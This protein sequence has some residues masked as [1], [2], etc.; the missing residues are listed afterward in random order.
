MKRL[1]VRIFFILLWTVM[2]LVLTVTA[3]MICSV[4]LLRPETLTPIVEKIA[5]DLLDAEVSVGRVKLAFDPSFP[6]LRLEVDSLTVVSDAL[7]ASDRSGLPAYAD[8]LL[9]LD[10]FSGDVDV[11]ALMTKGKIAVGDVEIVRPEVNIVFDREGRA[12]FDIYKAAEDTTSSEI[13][14]FS[15]RHF[16]F[17]DPKEIRYFNEADSAGATVLR[18]NEAIVEGNASDRYSITIEGDLY[19]PMAEMLSLDNVSL[20]VG[21]TVRW[22][23]EKKELIA[24]ED[25]TVHGAFL[26]AGFDTELVF[27]RTLTVR[28]AKMRVEPFAL[29]DALAIL[30]EDR[31]REYRLVD[32]FFTTDATVSLEA[33]LDRPFCVTTDFIPYATVNLLVPTCS[34]RYGKADIKALEFDGQMILRG[35][36]V[37][38]TVVDIRR[39]HISGPATTMNLT[40]EMSQ[41]LSD[42]R[43]SASLNGNMNLRRLPPVLTRFIPGFLS[44]RLRFNLEAKGNS[45]MFAMGQFHKLVVEGDID[46]N[47]IY[48]VSGDTAQMAEMDGLCMRF[49]S[50]V[51]AMS[52]SK[53]PTLGAKISVDTATVLLGG[54]NMT[55]SA[56]ELA[57]GVENKR[58]SAD[59]TLVV[60]LGGALKIGNLNII[61]VADSAGVRLRNLAGTASVQ[62]FEGEKR[63]P[64][65]SAD[66]ELGS[67][68]AGTRDTR[69]MM[70]DA[71]LHAKTYKD[72]VKARRRA[73]MK[74]TAD[75]IRKL[76]PDLTPDSVMRLAIE[77]HRGN[78]SGRRRIGTQ[79]TQN[80]NE[81]IDWAVSGGLRRYLLDWELEGELTTRRARLMTPFF[82]LRTR[83]SNLDI[84]FSTDTI[85]MRG[86]R[87]RVGRTDLSADGL[88]SNIKRALTS[89]RGNNTLKVDLVLESDTVDI[90]Q[91]ATAAFAG[92]AYAERVAA[93]DHTMNMTGSE[94]DMEA[95]IEKMSAENADSVGAILIPTNVEGNFELAAK[96]VLYD[97]FTFHNFKSDILVYDGAV[98][99]HDLTATSDAGN[100]AL[101]ALYSAPK[102]SEIQFGVGLQLE[103]FR[104]DRFLHLIPA[105]DSIMPIVRD[106]S[107][108]INADIAATMDVDS[109]MNMVLPT[110]DAAVRLSGDSLAFINPE[111]YATLG[112]WLRFRN[113]ADNKIKHAS[114]EMLV[115]D[116]MLQLFPFS[117]DIDRYRLGILGYN[118]LAMNFN[119]HI[120][121]LKSPLP[122][123][124]GV[125]IKGNPDKYKIRL[126]GA[127]YKENMALG[128]S[129]MV[130]TVR[131]NLVG[132][133]EN[134][135]RR[136]VRNSKFA[137][138]NATAPDSRQMLDDADKPF[139]AADS[140]ALIREGF[141]EAPA[142]P[143]TVPKEPEK[144][145]LKD[146]IKGVFKK[147]HD[148][149]SGVRR[150]ENE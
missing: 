124:F 7:K 89:R 119:Y 81:V 114:V 20:G 73:A 18:L 30:P 99:L 102:A 141:I 139:T 3:V 52:G 4:R 63:L 118:D 41:M 64:V 36:Q 46:G 120:S 143:V 71:A 69:F 25:F 128:N 108:I 146:K 33:V 15:I 13:P 130:D 121:V 85:V 107:G 147:N 137:T 144:K 65:I 24:L 57:A 133:I 34:M 148:N 115:R 82:P 50:R 16:T 23:Q 17:T 105:V 84:N 47:D 12:N 29:T 51:N 54:I 112:K 150:K 14:Q 79:L 96:N 60:P 61:S 138:I 39:F 5:N 21:G 116:N 43:F 111:T 97:N 2:A 37:D 94:D 122:F 67:V 92:S 59:T 123:K 98:N 131:V 49:N 145:S 76:H 149:D 32:P 70:R 91:L 88:V 136:G 28:S 104:I 27:G 87:C 35:L 127:K 42:P 40:A 72:P 90:N 77:K 56:L 113:R 68:F 1:I 48:Y 125:N 62:R 134:V 31:L 58:R 6:T 45:S 129:D 53:S 26:S 22:N 109:A 38:S 8:T 55:G 9:T 106:F 132:Q 117:F 10:A 135:F 66:L 93:G 11:L 101:S 74:H 75:S 100:V 126:G 80:D 19:G 110:L 78:R 86:V 142:E 83:L 140:A 44:G 103:G 95:A